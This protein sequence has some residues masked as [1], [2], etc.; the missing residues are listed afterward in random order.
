MPPGRPRGSKNKPKPA[1]DPVQALLQRVAELIE[2]IGDL[3]EHQV[4]LD[5]RLAGIERRREAAPLSASAPE[6]MIYEDG[7]LKIDEACKVAKIGRK[8]LYHLIRTN[9]LDAPK[10]GRSRRVSRAS[11]RRL[12][13]NGAAL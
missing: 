9:Q 4:M 1:A 12:V 13:Q 3:T 10:I 2:H 7:L 8:K 5:Q 6:P 11:L